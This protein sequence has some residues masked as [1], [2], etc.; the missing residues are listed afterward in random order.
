MIDAIVSSGGSGVVAPSYHDLRGWILKDVVKEV[1][2]DV[3]WCRTRGAKTGCSLLVSE[4]NSGKC[5]TLLN[6]SVYCPE[7]AVFI[8]LWMSPTFYILHMLCMICLRKLW[9]KLEFSM[10]CK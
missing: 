7:R 8:I 2:S 1:R 4:C 6:F 5:R 10:F 9:K 3:D